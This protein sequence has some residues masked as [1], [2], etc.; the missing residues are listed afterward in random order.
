VRIIQA[1]LNQDVFS[2]LLV[3]TGI[4]LLIKQRHLHASM[5]LLFF[6]F[7]YFATQIPLVSGWAITEVEKYTAQSIISLC[8]ICLYFSF[9]STLALVVA[10]IN[11]VILLLVN[12][13]FMLYDWHSWHHWVLFG[14]INWISFLALCYNYW[15]KNVGYQQLRAEHSDS[16]IGMHVYSRS[17]SDSEEN[18]AVDKAKA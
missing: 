5:C 12:I 16:K 15:I 13:L 8:L 7:G 6:I 18:Q 11:E 14:V 17:V 3:L 9:D 2:S 10:S 4:F 1:L